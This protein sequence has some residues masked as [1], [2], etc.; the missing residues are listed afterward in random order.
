[1]FIFYP[2]FPCI[3]CITLYPYSPV[4]TCI[5]INVIS[6]FL[7]M[8]PYLSIYLPIQLS[9]YLKICKSIHPSIYLSI[10]NNDVDLNQKPKN[11]LPRQTNY[12]NGYF[13]K[14]QSRPPYPPPP[15]PSHITLKPN[16]LNHPC[17]LNHCW[18]LP[19]NLFQLFRAFFHLI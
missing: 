8:Y 4:Y 11:I 12:R 7:F 14:T 13:N 10:S 1:M 17:L 18:V 9:I 6:V 5:P 15:S 2:F 3:S 19:I 16:H